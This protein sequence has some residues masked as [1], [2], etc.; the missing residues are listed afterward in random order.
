MQAF[1]VSNLAIPRQTGSSVS[2]PSNPRQ[3]G[4]L[5]LVFS[6]ECGAC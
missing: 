2:P 3:E 5:L 6:V 1:R 4:F